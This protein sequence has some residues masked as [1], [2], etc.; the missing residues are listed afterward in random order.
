MR[1]FRY[2]FRFVLLKFEFNSSAIK[3][4]REL[5]SRES[6]VE[7]LQSEGIG[8]FSKAPKEE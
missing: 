2:L 7:Q 6:F 8:S 5:S 4:F 1:L 3:W